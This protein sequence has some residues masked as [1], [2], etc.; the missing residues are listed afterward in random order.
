MPGE[1]LLPGSQT[2][3]F[4]VTSHCRRGLFFKGTN[5]IHESSA[6]ITYLL[7]NIHT[8]ED[9]RFRGR[10]STQ[11]SGRTQTFGLRPRPWGPRSGWGIYGA[12]A[13]KRRLFP[14]DSAE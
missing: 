13:R 5:P 10:A 7:P 4:P 2:A 3:V 12:Q 1:G 6:L 14:N 11:E 9:T 8:S